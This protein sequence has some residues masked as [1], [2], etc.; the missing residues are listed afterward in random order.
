MYATLKYC[1]GRTQAELD[2]MSDTELAEEY[3][4]AEWVLW[5]MKQEGKPVKGGK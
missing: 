2:A 3:N 5:A 4:E 1:F